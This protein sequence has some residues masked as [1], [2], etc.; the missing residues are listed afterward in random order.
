MI[1][2]KR[3]P[4][5]IETLDSMIGGGVIKNSVNLIAGGAGTGK[6]IFA[7]QFLV[8]G[9]KKYNEPG[10][11]ITFEEKKR[12]TYA[13]MLSFGWD[14]AKYEAQGKFIYLEYTPEQVKQ[15]LVEGGGVIEPIL[16][17]IKAKRIVID[18]ITSFS[19]LYYH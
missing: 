6:T 18:S 14:L 15:V 1:K 2:I 19:F 3:T 8:N 7:M 5:G 17:K 16:E 11:Y 9:I 4:I 10:I 13:D 12:K